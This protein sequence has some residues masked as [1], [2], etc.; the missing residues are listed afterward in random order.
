MIPVWVTLSLYYFVLKMEFLNKGDVGSADNDFSRIQHKT[1]L[2]LA[3][4]SIFNVWYGDNTW[5]IPI[6]TL[7]LEL[8][9]TFMV[10]LI[11]QTVIEYKYRGW[12]Y[13]LIIGF[14]LIP[15]LMVRWKF[16]Q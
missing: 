13:G 14:F 4:D 3:Y 9:A 10:Y 7:S 5:A 2:D 6:W 11:A 1:F 12:I 16:T 15:F 8:I